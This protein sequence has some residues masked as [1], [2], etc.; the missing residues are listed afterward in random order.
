MWYIFNILI[1]LQILD[2]FLQKNEEKEKYLN[3]WL[4]SGLL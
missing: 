2:R 1:C 4:G 3:K